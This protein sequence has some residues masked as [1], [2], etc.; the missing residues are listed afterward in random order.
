M[1]LTI[2]PTLKGLGK[3]I[4]VAA[5][6]DGLFN[7]GLIHSALIVMPLSLLSNWTKEF[8]TWAPESRV[9]VGDQEEVELTELESR[10]I[11]RGVHR[12]RQQVERL[13]DDIDV[14]KAGDGGMTLIG[15]KQAPAENNDTA[16]ETRKSLKRH[17]LSVK[18][19]KG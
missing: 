3:T 17:V 13:R 15:P 7:S 10:S 16:L 11:E 8:K 5:F 9:K 6:L 18:E 1:I 12:E 14:E 4:Q 19:D 2:I